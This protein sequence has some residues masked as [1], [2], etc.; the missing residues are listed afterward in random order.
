MKKL[1]ILATVFAA[2]TSGAAEA[3][4]WGRRG[5]TVNQWAVDKDFGLHCAEYWKEDPRCGGSIGPGYGGGQ[6]YGGGYYP[7]PMGG[8]WR[9]GYHHG[10]GGNAIIA[11]AMSQAFAA[12]AQE[13][14][15]QAIIAQQQQRLQYMQQAIAQN[16][17]QTQ[18]LAHRKY[19]VSNSGLQASLGDQAVIWYPSLEYQTQGPAYVSISN[20]EEGFFVEV[21]EDR[22][23]AIYNM[24]QSKDPEQIEEVMTELLAIAKRGHLIF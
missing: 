4:Y 23:L 14:R 3:Q 11:M 10:G 17:A 7:R 16:R 13:Q 8:G 20:G 21:R 19:P 1:L 2:L 18:F 22:Y 9:G 12:F 15:R 6:G 5:P 24:L